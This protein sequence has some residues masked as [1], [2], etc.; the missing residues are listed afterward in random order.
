MA[1][2][3]WTPAEDAALRAYCASDALMRGVTAAVPS[4]SYHAC[5]KRARVIGCSA[6]KQESIRRMMAGHDQAIRDGKIKWVPRVQSDAERAKR[7]ASLRSFY[8]TPERRAEQAERCRLA[9]A[10][11]D[12]AKHA[13]GVQ[14][15][16]MGWC[17]L[18]LRSTYSHLTKSKRLSRAEAMPLVLAEWAG[19]LR[20]ALRQIAEVA[21]PLADEQRRHHNSIEGQIE[22][23]KAGTARVVSTFKPGRVLSE[24]RS[25]IGGSMTDL[26]A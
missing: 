18:H 25:L 4:R 12:K 16:R 17:P 8:S 11:R 13:H 9:V 22:R 2:R 24:H 15:A 5:L 6:G 1:S 7:A 23:I 10:V 14:E 3:N 19:Q 20:L 26:A 21:K